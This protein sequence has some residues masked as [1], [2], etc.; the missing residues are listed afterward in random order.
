M[1]NL[2]KN[3]STLSTSYG[4]EDDARDDDSEGGKRYL[5][6]IWSL[7]WWLWWSR[8]MQMMTILMILRVLMTML[9][10]LSKK[11]W[12]W[13]RILIHYMKLS[14]SMISMMYMMYMM[15]D[16]KPPKSLILGCKTHN[17]KSRGSVKWQ[18]WWCVVHQN[19]A[20]S[21]VP[22]LRHLGCVGVCQV[23]FPPVHNF[24]KLEMLKKSKKLHLPARFAFASATW[25]PHLVL[26]FLHWDKKLWWW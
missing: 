16:Y 1:S 18:V 11:E 26:D 7:S 10:I 4:N 12:C 2:L 24:L 6:K 9:A 20:P 23:A 5:F 13:L 14:I 25:R 15:N 19:S 3:L 21:L 17:N 22:D 8:L